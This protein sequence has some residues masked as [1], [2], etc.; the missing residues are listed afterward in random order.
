M[1]GVVHEG[2]VVWHG[3]RIAGHVKTG[4]GRRCRARGSGVD[5][6]TVLIA[7][8]EKDIYIQDDL[9][10]NIVRTSLHILIVFRWETF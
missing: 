8:A 9:T 3:G 5:S 6:G 7:A 10:R 2:S 1:K 4:R